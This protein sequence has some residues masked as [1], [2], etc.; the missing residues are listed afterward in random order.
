[1]FTEVVS[2][3]EWWQTK[4]WT[5]RYCITNHEVEERMK[6]YPG[7]RRGCPCVLQFEP[8]YYSESF[9]PFVIAG[10]EQVPPHWRW[11]G[12]RLKTPEDDIKKERRGFVEW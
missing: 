12:K 2:L 7:C 5:C 3:V 4:K 8:E 10:Y 9:R 6:K 1:L 11:K